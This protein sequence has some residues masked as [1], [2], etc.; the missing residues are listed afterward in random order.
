M[1]IKAVVAHR[2]NNGV[3]LSTFK[4]CDFNLTVLLQEEEYLVL[5]A[6]PDLELRQEDV[7]LSWVPLGYFDGENYDRDPLKCPLIHIQDYLDNI[8]AANAVNINSKR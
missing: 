6:T 2:I 7:P 3:I 1:Q 8:V 4:F 5:W